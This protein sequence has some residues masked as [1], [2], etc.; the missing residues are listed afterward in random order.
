MAKPAR[1][2]GAPDCKP[3]HLTPA[4]DLPVPGR[5]TPDRI[6]AAIQVLTQLRDRQVAL[7]RTW[8]YALDKVPPGFR[9]SAV[10]LLRDLLRTGMDVMGINSAHDEPADWLQMAEHLRR[11]ERKTR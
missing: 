8:Q 11:A 7:A 6:G 2:I 1:I 3:V 4:G 10:N 9:S 5:F